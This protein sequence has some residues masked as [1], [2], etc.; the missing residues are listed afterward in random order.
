MHAPILFSLNNGGD[1]L[2]P[3]KAAPQDISDKHHKEPPLLPRRVTE[4]RHYAPRSFLHS[5]GVFGL[6]GS[7]LFSD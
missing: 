4:R 3:N 2:R 6:N 5:S 7:V 1:A